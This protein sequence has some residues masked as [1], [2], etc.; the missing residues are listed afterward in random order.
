MRPW[1]FTLRTIEPRHVGSGWI[2]GVLAAALGAIGFSAVACFHHPWLFTVPE[3]CA[4]SIRCPMSYIR[5]LL[6]LVL[7]LVSRI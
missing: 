7:V 3:H 2:S 5:A 1:R 4:R 6:H